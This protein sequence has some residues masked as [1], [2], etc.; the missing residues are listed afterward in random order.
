MRRGEADTMMT[1]GSVDVH[2]LAHHHQNNTEKEAEAEVI[3]EAGR[4]RLVMTDGEK[5][6]LVEKAA[7]MSVAPA[8]DGIKVVVKADLIRVHPLRGTTG[9]FVE[10]KR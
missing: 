1:E 4:R 5:A 6:H 2:G 3:V 7:L 8:A 9:L 10:R